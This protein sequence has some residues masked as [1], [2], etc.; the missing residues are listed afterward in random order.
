MVG[1][2]VSMINIIQKVSITY[3][4]SHRLQ[5][6]QSLVSQPGLVRGYQVSSLYGLFPEFKDQQCPNVFSQ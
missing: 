1:T 3:R 2:F 5:S 6:Q 4:A